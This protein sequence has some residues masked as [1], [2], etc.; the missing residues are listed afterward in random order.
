[1]AHKVNGLQHFHIDFLVEDKIVVLVVL[2][3][4]NGQ[5]SVT[6]GLSLDKNTV[7]SFDSKVV[8]DDEDVDCFDAVWMQD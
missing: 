1:M 5:I 8:I 3:K 4:D 7:P 6:W 2:S